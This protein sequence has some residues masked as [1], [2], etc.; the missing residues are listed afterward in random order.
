[1]FT[2]K[3]SHDLDSVALLGIGGDGVSVTAA[4]SEKMGAA[5]L[6]LEKDQEQLT[7]ALNQGGAR[8]ARSLPGL[9]NG[10]L[11]LLIADAH[12]PKNQLLIDGVQSVAGKDLPITGGSINKNAGQTFVYYRGNVY[13]DSAIGLLLTGDFKVAQTGNQAQSN[14][15]VIATAQSGSADALKKLDGKPFAVLAFNCGGRMGKLNRLQDELEA[16]QASIGPDLP[17]FGCYCAGEFGP[18]AD[19]DSGDDTSTGRGWHVM[20]SVLGH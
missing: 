3:G 17:L 14:E 19:A 18:A 15:K 6:S 1:M 4:L 13:P 10:T 8:L 7:Q 9:E 16:I 5:G 2:Q 12:S 20:F 11:L